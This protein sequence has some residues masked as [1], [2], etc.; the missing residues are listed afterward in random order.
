MR[1]ERA[2]WSAAFDLDP[3]LPLALWPADY[4]GRRAWE[5]RKEL[6]RLAAGHARAK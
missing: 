1:A 5:A 2:C 4:E 3:L 6:L